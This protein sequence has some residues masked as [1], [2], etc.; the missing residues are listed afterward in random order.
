MEVVEM[1]QL[2][3]EYSSDL[4]DSV[5]ELEV[6]DLTAS[7]R[8]KTLTLALD[9]LYRLRCYRRDHNRA[10]LLPKFAGLGPIE[11]YYAISRG[12]RLGRLTEAIIVARGEMTHDLVRDVQPLERGGL[13]PS[14]DLYPSECL[15]PRSPT[16]QWLTHEEVAETIED[17][18]RRE[19]TR[20]PYYVECISGKSVTL[21]LRDAQKFVLD[22][23][24]FGERA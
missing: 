21:T 22:D 2:F 17:L 23:D 20:W 10:Y 18:P 3:D 8:R 4:E 12:T 6:R 16:L 19:S 13:Y 14:E 9:S 24:L 11:T 7:A 15:Y 5:G 1:T